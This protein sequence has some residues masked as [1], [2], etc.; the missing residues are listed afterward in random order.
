MKNFNVSII[1]HNSDEYFRMTGMD[2]KNFDKICENV[3]DLINKRNDYG[4]SLKITSCFILDKVNYKE[5]INMINFADKLGTDRI[6][7]FHF[8]PTPIKGF[9]A[10]ERC[11]YDND[12][13]IL[14]TFK[15][16]DTLP[17][18]LKHKISLPPLLDDTMVKNRYC[19]TWFY[20]LSVDGD[21]N[22]GGC[23]CQLIDL[24]SG[25]FFESNDPF[26]N[27]YFQEMRRIFLSLNSNLL[28]PC[29]WCYNNSKYIYSWANEK[30]VIIKKLKKL[31]SMSLYK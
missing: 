25:K 24:N 7:F 2:P 28:E 4:S 21:E 10:E 14:E 5:L 20:N 31:F 16:I 23:S 22:I 3:I 13:L 18:N 15:K 6:A 9:S 8:L 12:K 29:T 1:S 17:K 11:L 19:S 30:N 26:N 27:Q